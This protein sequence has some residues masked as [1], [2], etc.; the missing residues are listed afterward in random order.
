[1]RNSGTAV[2]GEK[3]LVSRCGGE[4]VECERAR[5]SGLADAGARP[6]ETSSQR[7]AWPSMTCD[8]GLPP[9]AVPLFL[10]PECA[11]WSWWGRCSSA[12]PTARRGRCS[13]PRRQPR[14]PAPAWR[15]TG[16]PAPNDSRALPFVERPARR[17]A[18]P[19]SLYVNGPLTQGVSRAGSQHRHS[20][21]NDLLTHVVGLPLCYSLDKSGYPGGLH[22]ISPDR[23]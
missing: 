13:R 18:P 8:A 11:S 6:W 16:E 7:S 2:G 3:D 9:T 19:P 17:P 12:A 5:R 23:H 15:P 1:M 20:C 22:R 21:V 4:L 14:R 10:N